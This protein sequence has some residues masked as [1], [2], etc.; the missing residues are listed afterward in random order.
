MAWRFRLSKTARWLVVCLLV[1][2][3]ALFLTMRW[4]ADQCLEKGQELSLAGSDWVVTTLYS[5]CG[6]AVAGGYT[7][8]VAR[9][10]ATR[11]EV[12]LLDINDL[13]SVRLSQRAQNE[14]VI[15]LPNI[16]DIITMKKRAG[17]V[18]VTYQFTPHDDPEDRENY[19]L[20]KRHP[21]DPKAIAWFCA[22]LERQAAAPG[23]A[24][25]LDDYGCNKAKK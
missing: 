22:R 9:N 6:G 2:G 1:A 14:I 4:Q 19:Q 5:A 17:D 12:L 24:A 15:A 8:V 18:D 10:A 20:W 21:D 23:M 3:A 16:S 25:M 7:H 13:E 11:D